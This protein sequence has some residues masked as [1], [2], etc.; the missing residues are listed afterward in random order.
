MG[1]VIA[2]QLRTCDMHRSTLA[3]DNLLEV[4]WLEQTML[5]VAVGLLDRNGNG[6]EDVRG[7]LEDIVHLFQGTT[8]CLGEEEVYNREDK[9]VTVSHVSTKPVDV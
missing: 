6:I 3:A 2:V 8:A 5:I 7:L 4:L 9:C 1:T